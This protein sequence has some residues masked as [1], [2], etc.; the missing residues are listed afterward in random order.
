MR[1]RLALALAVA[2]AALWWPVAG[3]GSRLV[4]AR[5]AGPP[6]AIVMLASH[7]WERLPAAAALAR[8]YPASR[9]LL[10]VP[11][12]PSRFNCHLCS[13]RPAWLQREGVAAERIFELPARVSNTYDEALGVRRYVTAHALRRITV[14]T[15]PYHSRRAFQVF[16]HVLAGTAVE[17][18]VLPASASSPADPRRWLWHSYDRAYVSYEWAAILEYRVKYGVPLVLDK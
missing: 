15:S 9:V 2:L 1:R 17:L 13:E 10:T 3:A 8:A 14:V 4:V 12:A 16:A 18:G 6:D 5:P 7:E 11:V